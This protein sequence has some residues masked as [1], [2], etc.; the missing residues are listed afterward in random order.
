MPEEPETPQEAAIN[1]VHQSLLGRFAKGFVGL[2]KQILDKLVTQPT[3]GAAK[4]LGS[5]AAGLASL[6]EKYLTRPIDKAVGGILPTT[7]PTEGENLKEKYLKPEGVMQKV[8]YGVEQAAEL[9]T[10][11][12]LEGKGASLAAK[13]APEGG[14]LAKGLLEVGGKAAGGAVE[15]GGKTALQSGGNAQETG[16]AT[17]AGAVLPV[18]GA[19]LKTPLTAA[20]ERIYQSALKPGRVTAQEAKDLVKTGL[21]ERVFLTQGGVEKV[22]RKIDD[23]ESQLDDAIGQAKGAGATIKTAGMKTYINTAKKFF[24]DIVDVNKA[25]TATK[26]L[27]DLYTNFRKKYGKELPIEQAQKIKVATGQMLRKYYGE[28]TSAGIEGQKQAVR[29][30]KDEIVDAAPKVGNINVRLKALYQFDKALDSASKRMKNLNLLG[31]GAK[32]GAAAGGKEGAIIGALTQLLDSGALKSA[33][34]IGIQ[35]LANIAGRGAASGQVPLNEL[36]RLILQKSGGE[37]P[38]Q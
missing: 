25:E 3:I 12:G 16:A 24:S 10:P 20:A 15:Y 8:G 26:E 5:T 13:L 22:A 2:H 21:K 35:E 4:G 31:L 23:F 27:D 37:A 6:G 33:G 32:I 34:A 7:G 17:I 30:L 18:A 29:F 9:L 28:L 11:V 19:I 38:T 1:Q 36:V 14:K